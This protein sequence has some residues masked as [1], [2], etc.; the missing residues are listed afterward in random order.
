MIAGLLH[1]LE[2]LADRDLEDQ[3]DRQEHRQDEHCEGHVQR[4]DEPGEVVEDPQTPVPDRVGDRCANAYG[5]V[6]HDDVRELEHRFG[7]PFAPDDHRT[8]F[9]TDH[10]QRD[11]EEDAEDDDL[12]DVT[13]GHRVDDRLGDDVQEDLVPGLRLGGNFGALPHRQVDAVARPGNVDRQQ[14]DHE[15]DRRYDLEVDDGPE[16]HPSDD[17]EVTGPG[18]PGDERGKNQRR[19]DHLDHP[20]E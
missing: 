12:K 4:R 6:V 18:N 8:S 3:R 20:Q 19:D 17:F 14:A 11:S 9:F 1:R 13:F 15:R 5:C 2:E 10:A 16:T 7:H